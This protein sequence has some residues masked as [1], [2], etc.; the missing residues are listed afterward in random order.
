MSL[1]TGDYFYIILTILRQTI[2][3]MLIKYYNTD[4]DWTHKERVESTKYIGTHVDVL[5]GNESKTN[6]FTIIY[7]NTGCHVIPRKGDE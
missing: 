6:K 5:T 4:G 1:R 7:S 3:N 2:D